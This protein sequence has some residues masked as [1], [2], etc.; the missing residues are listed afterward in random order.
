MKP[1]CPYKD[2]LSVGVVKAAKNKSGTQRYKCKTCKRR[3]TPKPNKVGR[4]LSDPVAGKVSQ[5]E[6]SA[7]YRA[8]K[9]KEKAILEY[10]EERRKT[11]EKL[12]N[13]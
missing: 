11:L 3:F 7:R 12:N 4:K 8:R 9:R 2:C 10:E 6:A 5:K 1:V 13:E